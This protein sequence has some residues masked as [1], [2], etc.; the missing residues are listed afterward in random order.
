[1]NPSIP[2]ALF[3]LIPLGAWAA[4]SATDPNAFPQILAR[5]RT[6]AQTLYTTHEPGQKTLDQAVKI[7]APP[8]GNAQALQTCGKLNA[9]L[10]SARDV[11]EG[12]AMP[13]ASPSEIAVYQEKVRLVGVQLGMDAGGLARANQRY[14]P[15]GKPRLK[16]AGGAQSAA[17]QSLEADAVAALLAKEHL[18]PQMR[19]VLNHKA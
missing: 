18:S 12:C 3:L 11:Q 7:P 14:L 9:A 4:Q 13:C 8:A 19:A 15:Q 5:A 2:A 10:T 6:Q 1:M 17:A 16:R